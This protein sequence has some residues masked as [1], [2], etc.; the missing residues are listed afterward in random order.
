MKYLIAGSFTVDDTIKHCKE[1]I[2]NNTD[3]EECIM[4]LIWLEEL[5]ELR[6][7]KHKIALAFTE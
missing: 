4:L 2:D 6:Q 1:I 5:K 3:C 7:F